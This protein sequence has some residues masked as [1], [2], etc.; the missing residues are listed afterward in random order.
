MC[1]AHEMIVHNIRLR[2]GRIWCLAD[3]VQLQIQEHAVHQTTDCSRWSQQHSAAISKR[4]V[5][6]TDTGQTGL[7]N[8]RALKLPQRCGTRKS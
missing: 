2:A 8:I 3:H 1:E 4:P 7:A 5:P 6:G